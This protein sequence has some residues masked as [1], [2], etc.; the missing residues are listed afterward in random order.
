[1]T[2][3][4]DPI[5]A[6][7]VVRL[8]RVA[9]GA[10][11]WE[12]ALYLFAALEHETTL[13]MHLPPAVARQ[14]ERDRARARL[15]VAPDVGRE[16]EAAGAG[17][18]PAEAIRYALRSLG[19]TGPVV[20]RADTLGLRVLGPVEVRVGGRPIDAAAW[21]YR[22]S[23]DI[24]VYLACRGSATRH[25]LGEAFWPHAGP[26]QQRNRLN[27]C[28]YHLRKA[29]GD[30][31]WIQW[32]DNGYRLD[33]ER[34]VMCDL[35]EFERLVAAAERESAPPL[36]AYDAALALVTG[37]ILGDLQE[38]EWA[39]D[40]RE[41]MRM[42]IHRARQLAGQHALRMG[43]AATA[44]HHFGRAIEDDPLDEACVEGL[45]RACALNGNL[46]LLVATFERFSDRLEEE[47]GVA[48]T[49]SLRTLYGTLVTELGGYG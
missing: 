25:E 11:R 42:R 38:Q 8:S 14:A 40:E 12:V 39:R 36:Q 21:K 48:P 19:R 3:Q 2:A 23:R 31:S 41:R 22:H 28:L 37:E 1:V 7:E 27:V 6:W 46:T 13:A 18:S 5:G 16:A 9:V 47:M 10:R 15:A 17:A 4:G 43:D 26:Q 45:M 24:L 49:A 30:G 33:P 35:H 29:L 20:E 44:A 32:S 34:R